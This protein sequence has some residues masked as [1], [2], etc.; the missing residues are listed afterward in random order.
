MV[1][2]GQQRRAAG[3]WRNAIEDFSEALDGIGDEVASKVTKTVEQPRKVLNKQMSQSR[4]FVPNDIV[5]TISRAA[6]TALDSV[7]ST[8]TSAADKLSAMSHDVLSVKV[9]Q[10]ERKAVCAVLGSIA[11][12]VANTFAGALFFSYTEGWSLVDSVYFCVVTFST[13]GFGD[14]SPK[15]GY[16]QLFKYARKGGF[17]HSAHHA[18]HVHGTLVDTRCVCASRV[19]QCLLH[20]DWRRGHLYQFQRDHVKL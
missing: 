3:N 13:V 5:S 16:A 12:A 18:Y 9:K 4:A 19:P 2:P 14:M 17:E 7:T 11:L 8:A 6:T 1:L 10:A 15:N 20:C